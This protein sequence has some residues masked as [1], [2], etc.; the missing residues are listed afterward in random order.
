MASH[1]KGKHGP[2]NRYFASFAARFTTNIEASVTHSRIR[3]T[4]KLAAQS[5]TASGTLE[6]RSVIR[7]GRYSTSPHR[8]TVSNAGDPE[9]CCFASIRTL[10]PGHNGSNNLARMAFKSGSLLKS[11]FLFPQNNFSMGG[12]NFAPL[13]LDSAKVHVSKVGLGGCC[14]V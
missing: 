8:A 4:G 9:R 3:I 12:T 10:H 2:W 1:T 14:P 6:E 5:S 11:G 7:R 13:R